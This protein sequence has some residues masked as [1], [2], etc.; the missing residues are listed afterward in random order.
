MPIYLTT[1]K[2]G[3]PSTEI[4][5]D[6]K[7][8]EEILESLVAQVMPHAILAFVGQNWSQVRPE[9]GVALKHAIYEQGLKQ[10]IEMDTVTLEYITVI[11]LLD[12][13][14]GATDTVSETQRK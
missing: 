4:V 7:K 12:Y 9:L 1:T 6:E 8:Q 10:G 5:F 2:E 3:Q 13:H 11:T 14:D